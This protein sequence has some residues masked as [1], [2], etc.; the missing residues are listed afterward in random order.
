MYLFFWC[1]SSLRLLAGDILNEFAS[2]VHYLVPY[3]FLIYALGHKVELDW[4][5]WS[6]CKFSTMLTRGR[7]QAHLFIN[8]FIPAR[9]LQQEKKTVAK[10][11]KYI[12]FI[13]LFG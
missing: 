13:K 11:K 4:K 6:L 10:K 8:Q 12:E 5:K 9:I 3:V 7:R 2:C 1:G